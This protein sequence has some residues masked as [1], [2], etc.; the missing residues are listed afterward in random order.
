MP[1]YERPLETEG[2]PLLE[3]AERLR[4]VRRNAGNPT[5]RELAE[6]AH[7]SVSTLSAA[8]DGRR[9]PTLAVTL[10]YVG[11]CGGDLPEWERTWHATASAL[12]TPEPAE[13]PPAADAVR[14][15][16]AGLAAFQPEDADWFFGRERLVQELAEKLRRH[17]FV[18]VLGASGSGKSSLL[19]AGLVPRLAR[20]VVF[21]PG[22]RPLEE[23]AIQLSALGGGSPGALCAELS[24]DPANLHRVL[25]KIQVSEGPETEL[26]L[27]VDQFEELFT[28]GA[29]PPEVA[30]FVEAL[31]TAAGAATSRCRVVL[32]VRADFYAHCTRHPRLLEVLRDAVVPVGPMS[33]EELRRAIVRPAVRS[34]LTVEGALLATLTAQAHGRSGVL[35]LLSHALSETW[36]RRRGNAL[37]LAGFEA[38]GG[39]EG[40]L[41]RTAERFHAR[42]TAPQRDIARHVF[43]RLTALGDGTEDTRRRVPVAEWDPTPDTTAVLEAAAAARLLT[44]DRDQA[45]L[46]HEALIRCWPRLHGWLT[47]DREALRTQRQLTSAV[48]VWESL[49]RDP[50]ALFRGARLATA[51]RLTGGLTAREKEFLAAG[52]RAEE[53][54]ERLSQRRSRRMRQLVALLTVLLVL[55]VGSAATAVRARSELAQQRDASLAREV[56]GEAVALRSTQPALAG[57]LALAAYRLAPA[58]ATRSALLSSQA[59][60]LPA[61]PGQP[62]HTQSVSAVAFSPDGRLVATGSFDHTVRL[63]DLRD[64]LHPVPLPG[65]LT[66]ADVVSGLAFSPDGRYLATV[67]RERTVRVFSLADPRGPR[68][69]AGLTGHRDVVFSVAFS[70]DGRLLATGSYDHTVRLWDVHDPSRARPLAVLTGHHLNVKPVAFSPDGH[71]LVSGSDDRTLRLWDITDPADP[72]TLSVLTGHQDFV[73]AAV[74]SPDGHTLASGSDDHTIRLWDVRDLRHPRRLAVVSGHA[75]VVTALAFSPDGRR[76]LSG[77][78]DRTARITDLTDP[79]RPRLTNVLTGHLGAVNSVAFSPDGRHLLTGS[80]DHTARLWLPNLD[81]ARSQVC[82]H[83]ERPLS[84]GQW[85]TYFPDLAYQPPCGG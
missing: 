60:D 25:R 52:A 72:H 40:A 56:A 73:D 27:V 48:E 77:S 50:E 16:Y 46:T 31:A 30:A 37:T 70:P 84:Q 45:E 61:R 85:R 67:G 18:A 81:E 7:Y 55:A 58:D 22:P 74:F 17:R 42:L 12:D 63:W 75:D 49:G 69:L 8:A 2:G 29:G 19:R 59:V 5:Y 71:T 14:P 24:E 44:L 4:G 79:R 35:P 82:A 57:Q 3:F 13:E 32:G 26:V 64:P 20:A 53:E 6:R 54:S 83:S 80:S 11:A 43:T 33:L 51:R 28:Q 15:P 21:T 78:N 41:A 10:A 1:R 65:V 23:A 62:G 66:H 76:L 68:L 47:D 39:L 9:L 36:R 34:G 38:S